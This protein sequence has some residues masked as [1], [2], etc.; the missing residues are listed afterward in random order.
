[1]RQSSQRRRRNR[2]SASNAL[3]I[4]LQHMTHIHV[5]H[6]QTA[7]PRPTGTVP[8][9]I[10]VQRGQSHAQRDSPKSEESVAGTVPIRFSLHRQGVAANFEMHEFH[11]ISIAPDFKDA[12]TAEA[13]RFR[14]RHADCLQTAGREAMDAM[15]ERI[16]LHVRKHPPVLPVKSLQA[17]RLDEFLGIWIYLRVPR[18]QI[19]VEC[20]THLADCRGFRKVKADSLRK[21][22]VPVRRPAMVNL[23]LLT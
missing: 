22:R 21:L 19:G 3:A 8:R 1:M 6:R 23:T 2:R 16:F 17:I 13:P 14:H 4:N 9:T 11:A 15:P 12:G 10:H 7:I 20:Q 18:R 5:R